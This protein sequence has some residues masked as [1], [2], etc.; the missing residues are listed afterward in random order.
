MIEKF[1]QEIAVEAVIISRK[2]D[3]ESELK[4]QEEIQ[5]KLNNEV[6]LLF[7]NALFDKMKKKYWEKEHV[8]DK[9]FIIA[10]ADFILANSG[11]CFSQ[12]NKKG[13]SMKTTKFSRFRFVFAVI[14]LVVLI[15]S[16]FSAINGIEIDL[17]QRIEHLIDLLNDS[18]HYIVN[19]AQEELS[20]IGEP[21]F[22]PLIKKLQNKN[23]PKK[24]R[25][26]IL[27]IFKKTDDNICVGRNGFYQDVAGQWETAERC[28]Q[29][30]IGRGGFQF[31][32]FR[33]DG[34]YLFIQ[35]LNGRKQLFACRGAGYA[36]RVI[37]MKPDNSFGA[38]SKG[39]I[40]QPAMF[41]LARRPPI[42]IAEIRTN[43]LDNVAERN[44]VFQR[45]LADYG[46]IAEIRS[47]VMIFFK[48]IAIV[49]ENFRFDD[50]KK[51]LHI[52]VVIVAAGIKIDK[53]Q[54]FWVS[55]AQ[56]GNDLAEIR[57]GWNLGF[58]S[59]KIADH[60]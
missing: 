1:N 21:T 36:P 9:P 57:I 7:G 58:I 39:R 27:F 29:G 11:F 59:D 43:R 26:F 23:T 34:L 32:H 42:Q 4:S 6:P 10:I 22:E 54:P 48:Y 49:A 41:G 8:K 24:I 37:P 33:A 60:R 13:K 56:I 47:A 50:F 44:V 55:R 28:V 17:N 16:P 25:H 31:N 30:M 51:L 40:R 18:D 14:V 20:R 5:E 2:T 12:S 19:K 52:V 45:P 38:V 35:L 15:F 3:L 46:K 53:A